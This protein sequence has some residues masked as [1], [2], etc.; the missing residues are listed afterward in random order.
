MNNKLINFN[1]FIFISKH[2]DVKEEEP[3]ER[4]C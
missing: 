2:F 1:K 4:V 3:D